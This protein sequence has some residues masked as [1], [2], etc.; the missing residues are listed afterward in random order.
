MPKRLMAG[1]LASAQ[2]ELQILQSQ[3]EG[4]PEPEKFS[5]QL[6]ALE[7]KLAEL[8]VAYEELEQQNEELQHTREAL[9]RQRHRYLR[10]F[11]EAP[12]GYLVTDLHGIIEEANQEAATMIGVAQ[13]HLRGK[14][15]FSFVVLEDRPRLRGLLLQVRASESAGELEVNIKPR[16]GKTFAAMLTVVRDLDD[17]T[18]TSRLRWSL[19]DVSRTKAAEEALRASEERLRHSQRMESVGRLAGGIAHSFNNL[20]AAMA[21]QCELLCD[22]LDEGDERRVHVDEI[23]K[24]GE[25]AASLARQLLAFGRRQVLQPR[26]LRLKD[27]VLELEPMLRRVLGEDIRLET[28]LGGQSSIYGNHRGTVRADLGQ[29]E[30]VILNL[31]VNARDA[32]PE[33]GA[34]TLA[35]EEVEIAEEE[36]PAAGELP[37]G[38]YVQLTVADTGTGMPPEVRERLFEPFFTTKERGKGTG[39]GLATVHGIVHQSG[40]H[41]EVD[42]KPGQGTRFIVLLPA[43]MEDGEP[44]AIH[45]AR[46]ARRARRGSEVVLLVEDEDNIREPAI[47][48]LESRGYRVIAAHDG[49]QA[50]AM[51]EE[52]RG[53]IHLL[54]TDVVMP[55]MS[56]NQVAQQLTHRRPETRVLYISGYPEDSISHHG[57]LNPEQNFLQKPFPPG[58]FLEKIREVLDGAVAT[59]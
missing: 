51:A 5:A 29:I 40:G 49:S 25:R 55:G 13:S 31:V 54:V 26:L 11:D 46:P 30:Q 52:H 39:L 56:G 42:S 41:V 38:S 28:R 27:V 37:P 48:I 12:F 1:K 9:E 20:L 50:L 21:F 16:K 53:P 35:V 34:L 47:E 57:V 6:A 10:L 59:P 45:P 36:E 43:A 19:R 22:R 24:A 32:M 44:M 2:R 33:G 58:Q 23:Q 8:D 18:R 3:A 17:R 4:F 15:F 7:Q 14:P